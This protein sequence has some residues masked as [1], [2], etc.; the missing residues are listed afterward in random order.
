[1]VLAFGIL[2]GVAL[3]ALGGVIFVVG[4]ATWLIAD[5]RAYQQAGEPSGHGHH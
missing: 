3:I 4:I 5:A 2:F 1:M